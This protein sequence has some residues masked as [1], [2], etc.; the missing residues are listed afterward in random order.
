MN[1]ADPDGDRRLCTGKPSE[2]VGFPMQV[3]LE[4][5]PDARLEVQAPMVAVGLPGPTMCG[6]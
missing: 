2:R 4:G 5:T 6:R 3:T 1:C